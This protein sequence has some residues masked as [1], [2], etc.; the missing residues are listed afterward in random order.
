M[1]AYRDEEAILRDDFTID[2]LEYKKREKK[3]RSD[4]EKELN[5]IVKDA[6][7][8][9]KDKMSLKSFKERFNLRIPKHKIR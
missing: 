2:S 3:L 6:Y 4:F 1:D 9:V 8:N 5:V 7:S